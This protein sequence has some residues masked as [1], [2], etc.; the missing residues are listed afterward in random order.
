MS[1]KRQLSLDVIMHLEDLDIV[2]VHADY[3][4]GG[5]SGAIDEIIYETKNGEFNRDEAGVSKEV[6]EL[7]ENY[8]YY[9]LDDIEDWY[10]NDGGWGRATILVKERGYTIENNVRYYEH[11]TYNHAGAINL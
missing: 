3:S 4:G 5:D 10:N 8:L 9:L 7:I 2:Q 11:D 1:N 6:H